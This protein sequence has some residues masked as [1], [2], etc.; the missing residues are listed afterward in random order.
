MKNQRQTG[1]SP[2]LPA[3]RLVAASVSILMLALA[4]CDANGDPNALSGL[5]GQLG[6]GVVNALSKLLEAGLLTALL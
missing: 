5:T 6:A 3:H 2:R 4:G 1:A